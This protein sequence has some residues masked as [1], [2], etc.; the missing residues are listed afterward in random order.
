MKKVKL[1]NGGYAIV[2]DE[3][4]ERVSKYKWYR[5]KKRNTDCAYSTVGHMYLHRYIL[6]N[7]DG[8]MIDHID[9]NGLNN[10]RDNLRICTNQQ[11]LFNQ[12]IKAK[13]GLKGI[14]YRLGKYDA[15]L[16]INGKQ[17]WGGRFKNIKEAK[18]QYNELSKKYH[19]EYGFIYVLT[20]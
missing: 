3:D 17:K 8:K 19:G 7:P 20:Q 2:S 11:N 4:F 12:T 10:C 13:S 15:Y 9:H 18:K 5:F 1:T 16:V 14:R 6:N